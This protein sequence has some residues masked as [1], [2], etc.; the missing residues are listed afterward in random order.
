M[1]GR[2]W[3][4]EKCIYPAYVV[5]RVS[6]HH[7]KGFGIFLCCQGWYCANV[8]KIPQGHSPKIAAQQNPTEAAEE[9]F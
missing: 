6:L 7:Q 9:E 2:Q 4:G 8:I 5:V 1:A 3:V